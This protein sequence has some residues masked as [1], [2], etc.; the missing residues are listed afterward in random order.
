MA[1]QLITMQR[2]RSAVADILQYPIL[3]KT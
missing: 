3:F 2:T 1:S